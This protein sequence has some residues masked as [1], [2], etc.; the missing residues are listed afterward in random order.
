LNVVDSSGWL[1]YF[2]DGL[3]ADFFDEPLQ[4]PDALVVPAITIYEVFKSVL[5]QR[6]E[7]LA[8][9]VAAQMHLGKV[10]D[11]DADLAMSAAKLSVNLGLPMA[12]SI[13]MATALAHRATVWTQDS[14][15]EG[16]EGV[17]YV[18]AGRR[19]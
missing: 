11:L 5:R 1:E 17:R 3:N 14:D 9:R 13:I 4:E 2:A 10:V 16:L 6:G 8:L 19:A 15:F 7:D 12:D 18:P